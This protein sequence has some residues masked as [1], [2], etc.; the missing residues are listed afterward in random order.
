MIGLNSVCVYFCLSLLLAKNKIEATFI[1]NGQ[2]ITVR[3]NKVSLNNI[4][5]DLKLIFSEEGKANRAAYE[6][7]ER[8]AMEAKQQEI[9]A[10]RRNP[11]VGSEI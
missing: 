8:A 10:R 7:R 1:Q 6:E 4:F 3:S 9:L 2:R 11:E 5:D